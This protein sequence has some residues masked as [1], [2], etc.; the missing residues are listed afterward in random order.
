MLT[1]VSLLPA[2][3]LQDRLVVA[4]QP[5]EVEPMAAVRLVALGLP[6]PRRSLP[7][8]L[9]PLKPAALT[10]PAVAIVREIDSVWLR[11]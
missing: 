10:V 1:Q 6:S 2:V 8:P 4:Q 3:D 7:L 11:G 5:A 9:R